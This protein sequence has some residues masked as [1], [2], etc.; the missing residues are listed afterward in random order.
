MKFGQHVRVLTVSRISHK[1]K[2]RT[3]IM[4]IAGLGEPEGSKGRVCTPVL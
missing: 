3:C 4:G 2:V 1:G